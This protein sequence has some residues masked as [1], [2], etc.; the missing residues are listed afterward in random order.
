MSGGP[1]SDPPTSLLFDVFA[2]DQ[3]V[4]RLL[5][6]YMAD[7]PLTPA[8]YAFYSAIFETESIKPSA[9]AARMGMPLTTVM[10]HIAR[11]ETRGHV[12][13]MSDPLDGRASRVVLTG[14]GLAAHRS[15]NASFERAHAAFEQALRA[16]QD[17]VK[18]AIATIRWA[19]DE[20]ARAAPRG[21]SLSAHRRA[22]AAPRQ[23]RTRALAVRSPAR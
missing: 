12:A 6:L 17:A 5:D 13:R 16:D 14:D 21:P 22:D 9:L 2:A 8:E 19:V 4:G 18:D 23:G 11:L 1:R 20:A 15:A 7:S 10:D 3:A